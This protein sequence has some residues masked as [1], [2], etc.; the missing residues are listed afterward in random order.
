MALTLR[1]FETA[2]PLP[3]NY[4]AIVRAEST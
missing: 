3:L 2:R 4:A 1:G